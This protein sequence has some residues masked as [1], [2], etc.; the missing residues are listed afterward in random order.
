MKQEAIQLR[1][2]DA[3][4]DVAESDWDALL[5]PDSGPFLKYAFLNA[6]E[7]TGC[8]GGNTGWQAA[9]LI[10]EDSKSRLLGAMPLYLKRHSSRGH[11]KY[12]FA[13]ISEIRRN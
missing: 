9:H 8:V 2:I 12:S 5:T 10:I 6:L 3:L 13:P 7:K 1:I 4:S 11:F